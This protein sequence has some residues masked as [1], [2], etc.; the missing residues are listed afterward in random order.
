MAEIK[1][2]PG[3][4][5]TFSRLSPDGLP[6]IVLA[7][8]NGCPIAVVSN[9]AEFKENAQLIAA[10]PNLLEALRPFAL[11][12]EKDISVHEDDADLFQVMSAHNR[13]PK[14]TVGDFRKAYNELMIA[15]G[16][17]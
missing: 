15:E 4:W 17:S 6:E 9:H 1:H 5:K 2:T 7:A 14:L 10:S 11:V 8:E 16:R 12:Y 13:A 3:P